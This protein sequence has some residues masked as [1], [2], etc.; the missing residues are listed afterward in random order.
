MDGDRRRYGCASRRGGPMAVTKPAEALFDELDRLITDLRRDL[1]EGRLWLALAD[2][3]ET[4]R[5]I[6]GLQ[7][8]LGGT[9]E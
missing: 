3:D 8:A 6:V 5:L 1:W 9:F 2:V 7:S 4:R